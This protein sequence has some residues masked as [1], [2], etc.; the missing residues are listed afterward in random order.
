M[1]SRAHITEATIRRTNAVVRKHLQTLRAQRVAGVITQAAI[2][3]MF[4]SL[5]TRVHVDVVLP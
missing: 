3:G 1:V 5:A 2:R 4:D